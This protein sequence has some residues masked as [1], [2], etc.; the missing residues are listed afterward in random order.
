[1]AKEAPPYVT[2]LT[3]VATSRSPSSEIGRNNND[4]DKQQYRISQWKMATSFS[5]IFPAITVFFLI[6]ILG[7]AG[8]VVSQKLPQWTEDAKEQLKEKNI[9]ISNG[10]VKFGVK[11]VSNEEEMDKLQRLVVIHLLSS[12]HELSGCF[13]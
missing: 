6:A 8:F 7:A 4:S 9:D 2:P 12:R 3:A 11:D 1:M 5:E 13:F 10:G